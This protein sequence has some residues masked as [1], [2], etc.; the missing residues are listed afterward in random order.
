MA[1][2]IVT[3]GLKSHH[4][5]DYVRIVRRL[6]SFVP[7]EHLAGIAMITISGDAPLEDDDDV[8]GQYF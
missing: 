2:K 3:S 5:L 7:P 1:V 6:V 8:L 4:R